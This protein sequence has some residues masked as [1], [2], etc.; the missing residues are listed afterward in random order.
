MR[1]LLQ[2]ELFSRYVDASKTP[3]LVVFMYEVVCA[4]DAGRHGCCD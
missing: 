3:S 4:Y 2:L 1:S